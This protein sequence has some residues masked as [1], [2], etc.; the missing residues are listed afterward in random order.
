M[1]Q[2]DTASASFLSD[3]TLK[4]RFQQAF[5]KI[6]SDKLP[7]LRKYLSTALTTEQKRAANSGMSESFEPNEEIQIKT[8]TFIILRTLEILDKKGD[9]P[10]FISYAQSL[11]TAIAKDEELLSQTIQKHGLGKREHVTFTHNKVEQ[12]FALAFNEARNECN[13]ILN[14]D[15]NARRHPL[16]RRAALGAIA[17]FTLGNIPPIPKAA[18]N[19]WQSIAGES[20]PSYTTQAIGAVSGYTIGTYLDDKELDAQFAALMK[21][22][23]QNNISLTFKNLLEITAELGKK[24]QETKAQNFLTS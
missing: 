15:Y 22:Q 11:K 4:A 1:K 8:Q 10:A 7:S 21:A 18:K 5:M 24:M 16:S 19:S 2:P 17:G 14:P 3:E 20:L 9:L 23:G 13:Q 6:F 12:N